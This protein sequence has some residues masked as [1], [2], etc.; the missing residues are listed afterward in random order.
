[1]KVT[2]YQLSKIINS[3]LREAYYESKEENTIISIE[4]LEER[5]SEGIQYLEKIRKNEADPLTPNSDYSDSQVESAIRYVQIVLGAVQDAN[6]SINNYGQATRKAVQAYQR[7]LEERMNRQIFSKGSTPGDTPGTVGSKTAY[8]II[9][10]VGFNSEEITMKMGLPTLFDA[11]VDQENQ[12]VETSGQ[13]I[14]IE[15]VLRTLLMPEGANIPD[16]EDTG[17]ELEI[18][19]VNYEWLEDLRLT[20]TTRVSRNNQ[21]WCAAFVNRFVSEI[22]QTPGRW[23]A[24]AWHGW[25]YTRPGNFKTS[26]K[27][28]SSSVKAKIEEVFNKIISDN[29]L[30]ISRADLNELNELTKISEDVIRPGDILGLTA[31]VFPT[32]WPG[33]AFFES[34]TNQVNL[35]GNRPNASGSAVR[36]ITRRG[37][38][39]FFVESETNRPYDASQEY[40][41]G[42]TF[43]LKST[44]PGVPAFNSHV[45]VCIGI[46]NSRP[47][48]MHNMGGN[49]FLEQISDGV[50]PTGWAP[51]WANSSSNVNLV[52]GRLPDFDEL[53]SLSEESML[54]IIRRK[55]P[56]LN[57]FFE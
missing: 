55:F 26:L 19:R 51:I 16:P 10:K 33:T 22:I 50:T 8:S 53:F 17:T 1:M 36:S 15:E 11:N 13:I 23:I 6:S 48:V 31:F 9:K 35:E 12:E 47:I 54:D 25:D 49:T 20:G 3:L 41:E 5:F 57:R 37:V 21:R 45:G 43:K 2:K 40:S 29:Y 28:P 18:T 39:P 42:T 27:N 56:I 44:A 32:D 4:D 34:A 46:Y 30:D 52:K 7:Y 14:I 24:S 38:S